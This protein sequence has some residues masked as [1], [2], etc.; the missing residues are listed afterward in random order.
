MIWEYEGEILSGGGG[1]LGPYP[2]QAM[3][4]N[5]GRYTSDPL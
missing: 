4:S 3:E 5:N 2:N 1:G